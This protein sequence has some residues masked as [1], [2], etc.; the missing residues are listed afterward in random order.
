MQTGERMEQTYM[1][2]LTVACRDFAN[3]PEDC[4]ILP[5]D[6]RSP[7]TSVLR[8]YASEWLIK[9]I[10]KRNIPPFLFPTSDLIQNT[11][12]YFNILLTVHLNIFIS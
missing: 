7:N 1:T 9:C 5:L 3:A 2:K 8:G 12:R 6:C 4:H 10:S 11:Q